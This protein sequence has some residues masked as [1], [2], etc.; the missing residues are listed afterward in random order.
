M[1]EHDE[2]ERASFTFDITTTGMDGPAVTITVEHP[3]G[4]AMWGVNALR[5]M[6]D[7]GR[8]LSIMATLRGDDSVELA[9]AS[10]GLLDDDDESGK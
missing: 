2:R 7:P 6:A 4:L 5:E 3:P 1:P 10:A 9:L 8:L